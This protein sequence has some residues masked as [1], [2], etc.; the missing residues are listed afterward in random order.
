M[1]DRSRTIV[2]SAHCTCVI[3]PKCSEYCQSSKPLDDNHGNSCLND[4]TID[5][6]EMLINLGVVP[7]L[8]IPTVEQEN[9]YTQL[10]YMVKYVM[11]VLL[12][13]IF[14]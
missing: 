8:L 1:S 14:T 11:S 6:I 3:V 10:S 2:C 5:I 4:I 9:M 13:I 7:Q 12:R